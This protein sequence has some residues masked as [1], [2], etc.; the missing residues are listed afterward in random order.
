MRPTAKEQMQGTCRILE[1][2]IAPAVS[3]P[4][5]RTILDNLIANLRMLT[6]ALPKVAGFLRDDNAATLSLLL[7]MRTALEADLAAR[8]DAAAQA[9][10]PDLAD[11]V[12]MEER[13]QLLRAL[14][15]EAVCSPALTP[16]MR[17]SIEADMIS[18][19][20]RAPMRYVPNAPVINTLTPEK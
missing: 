9:G 17:Q 19:A 11:G 6:G 13:S 5:A 18:R 8:I 14:L 4:Y 10:E 2:V 15:A 1:T 20:S 7:A 12:A 3:E 16:D